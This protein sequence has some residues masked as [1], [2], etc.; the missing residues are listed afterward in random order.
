MTAREARGDGD[1]STAAGG[2]VAFVD[3]SAMVALADSADASHP[4]AVAGYRELIG[5]GFQLLTTELALAE[6]HELLVAALGPE[7]A[8]YWLQQC[9]IDILCVAPSDIEIARR[10]IAEGWADPGATLAAAIHLAVLD[11]L[12]ITDVFAVDRGFLALLG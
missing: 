8:R 2:K 1:T 7:T 12:E 3:A 11:R 9:K 5:S 6:A 4:A 10:S